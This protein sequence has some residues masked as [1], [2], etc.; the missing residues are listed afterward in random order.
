MK[1]QS[2]VE[3]NEKLGT[4]MII[5]T[6]NPGIALIGDRIVRMNSGK[7]VDIKENKTRMNPQEIPWG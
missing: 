2:L 7:I 6:H 5:V 1:K 3:A 4:T